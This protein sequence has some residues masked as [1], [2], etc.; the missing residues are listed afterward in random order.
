MSA[1]VDD[2]RKEASREA[3]IERG[4]ERLRIAQQVLTAYADGAGVTETA[5]RIGRSVSVTWG[6]CVW[7]GVQTGRAHRGGVKRTGSRKT[8]RSI[9]ELQP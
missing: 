6:L 5:R 2:E 9:E 3:R 4:K 1:K 7:L 8:R